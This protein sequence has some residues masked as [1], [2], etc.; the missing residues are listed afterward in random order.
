MFVIYSFLK[1]DILNR[2]FQ[3][4]FIVDVGN[5]LTFSDG[6]CSSSTMSDIE[7]SALEVARSLS[8]QSNKISRTPDNVIFCVFSKKKK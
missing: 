5:N 8:L 7:I 3:E 6:L 2:T 1:C 4:V